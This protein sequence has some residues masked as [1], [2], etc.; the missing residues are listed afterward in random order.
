[1]KMRVA[2]LGRPAVSKQDGSARVALTVA[3]GLS[4]TAHG[5]MN[6]EKIAE[7]CFPTFF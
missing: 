4:T 5:G 3:L 2:Q 7:F 6:D 1:M